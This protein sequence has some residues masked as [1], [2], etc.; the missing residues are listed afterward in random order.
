MEG[1]RGMQAQ[2]CYASQISRSAPGMLAQNLNGNK[3]R[4]VTATVIYASGQIANDASTLQL[5]G[6]AVGDWLMTVSWQ[7]TVSLDATSLG[8]GNGY[9]LFYQL[10]P[11]DIDKK[12]SFNGGGSFSNLGAYWI[13]R[14]P[15]NVSNLVINVT[16]TAN[17]TVTPGYAKNSGWLGHLAVCRWLGSNGNSLAGAVTSPVHVNGAIVNEGIVG[18]SIS[19]QLMLPSAAYD[20]SSFTWH[21]SPAVD[22][23]S[24]S[25]WVYEFRSS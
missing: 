4:P 12:V 19:G 23:A 9:V 18:Q 3:R 13:I 5:R 7:N 6:A 1:A 21:A 20:G 14:G 11:G 8:S 24:D 15:K 25:L 17:P 10:Q 2:S 22:N 16:R